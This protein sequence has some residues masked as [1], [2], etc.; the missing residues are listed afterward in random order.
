MVHGVLAQP[1]AEL[2]VKQERVLV[3]VLI[4]VVVLVS[5]LLQKQDL[6]GKLLCRPSGQNM[7]RGLPALQVVELDT[8]QKPE[9]ASV[10]INV[11]VLVLALLS[12]QGHVE[13]Q[14]FLLGGHYLDPGVLVQ[15]NVE[16]GVKQE[17]VLASVLIHVE[18]AVLDLLPNID[19]VEKR[20]LMPDGE[21]LD[22]GVLAL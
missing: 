11:V 5:V 3:S 13:K 8:K 15:Q 10:L 6:A 4:H 21:H 22:R 9:P 16:S 7:D 1:N 12:Y 19:H 20:L 18:V 17:P 2:D 14:L